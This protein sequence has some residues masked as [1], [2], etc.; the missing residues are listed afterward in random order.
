MITLLSKIEHVGHHASLM[1]SSQQ[2]DK[3]RIVE[4]ICKQQC[5]DFNTGSPPIDIISK[6]K[7]LL[8]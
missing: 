7:V 5:N 8:R 2:V 4:L 6:K 3:L 1:V